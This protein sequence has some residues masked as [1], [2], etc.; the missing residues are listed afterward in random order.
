MNHPTTSLANISS[1]LLE[2][3]YITDA[4]VSMSVFLSLQLNKPL[5]IEGPAGVGKTEI[6]KVM[7][8]VLETDLIRLQ[9]YEGLDAAHA[10]YEWNY[11]RQLL[12]LKMLEQE[13]QS[14]EDKEKTIFS[15][16]FLMKRP[17]LQAIT[18]HKKPVL[19]IDEVDRSDE[20]FE[21][22]LLEVLSEWQITIPETGT[23]KATHI[24]QVILTSN[25]TRELSEALRRRCLY[26]HIGYPDFEKEWMIVSKKVP[27]IDV[28]LGEQICRFMQNLRQMKLEKTPGIAETLDWALALSTLHISHLDK[29]TVEQTLGVIL[30][31]WQDTRQVQMSLSELLEKTGIYSKLDSL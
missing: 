16:A 13:K 10:L 14:V 6:A 2:Q 4:S 3:G 8:R 26:L 1:L 19:L 25:R 27:H 12:H 30:K 11:Q 18:H 7:A 20:E 15:E 29:S 23:I 31:D 21:S 17:L 9:C 28:K 22:F 24:P 5:L